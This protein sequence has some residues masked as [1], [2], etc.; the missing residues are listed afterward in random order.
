MWSTPIDSTVNSGDNGRM[1]TEAATITVRDYHFG[2]PQDKVRTWYDG[3]VEQTLFSNALSIMFPEGERFFIKSVR[4]FAANIKD[5]KLKE[6]VQKFIRQEAL[7]TR[8]HVEYNEALEAAGYDLPKLEGY[9]KSILGWVNEHTGPIEQ[10]AVTCALEHFTSLMAREF[11]TGDR[12]LKNA[13]PAFKRLW[14]WHALEEMEHKSVSYDTFVTVAGNTGYPT[15]VIV[16][17][18]TT[19]IFLERIVKIV[20]EMMKSDGMGLTSRFKLAWFLFGKPGFM[21]RLILPYLRYYKPGFK[22]EDID[23]VAQL[24][25]GFVQSGAAAAAAAA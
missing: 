12:Y 25:R 7:H 18:A 10:L 23:D 20:G 2:L 4:A 11:M 16:M 17:F 3:K 24:Q 15:R 14:S 22:P 5:P 21:R 6:D 8:E 13:D 9:V 1:T 19:V